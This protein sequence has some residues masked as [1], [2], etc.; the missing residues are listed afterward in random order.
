MPSPDLQGTRN[1]GIEPETFYFA[2]AG[3]DSI[4]QSIGRGIFAGR[5]YEASTEIYTKPRMLAATLKT[6]HR[7][8]SCANCY[9]WRHPS[10]L[11]EQS[12][13]ED[14]QRCAGCRVFLYCNKV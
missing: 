12:S 4:G 9:A 3:R 10:S 6:E 14:L 1:A 2:D 11:I 5:D 8:N 7:K 13:V